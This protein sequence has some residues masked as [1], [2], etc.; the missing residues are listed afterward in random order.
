[1]NELICAAAVVLAVSMFLI[2]SSIEKAFGQEF[3]IP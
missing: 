3:F 2:F 1:M